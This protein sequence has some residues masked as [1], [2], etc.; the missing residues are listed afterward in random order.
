MKKSVLFF[1]AVMPLFFWSCEEEKNAKVEVWLT[2][3]P[4][5][6]QEVNI[7]LLE[8]EIKA[9][10]TEDETGWQ[11]LDVTPKVYNLL[12]WTNGKETFLGGAEVPAGRLSQIRLK[13]GENNSVKVDGTVQP[14]NTPSAQQS[15]L[16]LN[17]NQ[18]LTEGI[19]YKITLDFEAGKSIVVTGNNTYSLKPV[20][21]VM[22]EAQ[23]GAIKGDIEPAGVVSIAV[24]SGEETVTTS[25]SDETGQ[26][27]IQGLA[28]GTYR[29]VFDPSGD[30]PVVEKTDVKVNLGEVTDIGVID[31]E[32]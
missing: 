27:L 7:D 29:L 14:L 22:T 15:G 32:Q 4:A 20:I 9:S 19:T 26:F 21:R 28:A 31:I 8:V 30:A 6:F 18:V 16:K 5:D 12:D 24:M 11:A 25:S 3:A 23:D 2:D 17:I 10:D 1:V 13:L